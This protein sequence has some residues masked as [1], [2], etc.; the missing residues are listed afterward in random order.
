MSLKDPNIPLDQLEQVWR[1]V[2]ANEHTG[3]LVGALIIIAI[4]YF[5]YNVST[6]L[7]KMRISPLI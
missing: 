2:R 1:V 7:V 3:S 4:T 6:A 5:G